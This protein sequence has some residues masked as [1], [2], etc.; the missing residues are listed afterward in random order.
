[1]MAIAT[2]ADLRDYRRY[3]GNIDARKV[4]QTWELGLRHNFFHWPLEFKEVFDPNGAHRGFDVVLGNPPWERIKLQEKEWFANR[5]PAIANAPNAAARHQ[6]IEA[7][8]K[9][10]PT[11]H[12]E[13]LAD[14][15][16][17][18]CG[19]HFVRNSGRYPLCGRGDVNT[20][21][22]FAELARQLINDRGRVGII[23]PTGIA[24]DDTT[25]YFFQSLM[26]N[27]SLVSLYD[28]ENR[29]KLFSA[30]D[31][32]M[33]FCLLTLTGAAQ[34]IEQGAEFIFFAQDV[35]E[36]KDDARRFTLSAAEI[37]LLNPNTRTC[38]IF[39]SKRDAELT[40]AIYQRVPVLIKESEAEENPWGLV[41]RR[42]YDMNKQ[43]VLNKCKKVERNNL[44]LNYIPMMESKLMHQFDSRWA[45][46]S[47]DNLQSISKIN[48]SDSKLEVNP[49][50]EIQ[51]SEVQAQLAGI[52]TRKWLLCWRDI[53]RNTDER[54]I[55]CSILPLSGTDFTIRVGFPL[56]NPLLG[57]V[58]LISSFNSFCVDYIARQMVSGTHLSDYITK[59]LALL[60]ISTFS[61]QCQWSASS[62]NTYFDW[63][64]PRV[65]ELTYTAWDLQPFARDCGY[66]GP[67]FRW[68]EERRFLLR[69]ELDAAYFHLY[70][71]A[72]DDVTY[73]LETF[74]I[75]KRKDEERYGVYR[76]QQ[77][78][79]AI[80]DA[81]AQAITTGVAY[82]TPLD[83]PPADMRVAHGVGVQ[84]RTVDGDRRQPIRVEITEETV[85]S[86]VSV[87]A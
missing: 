53:C 13:F 57:S 27:R 9:E 33:K 6:Q 44:S 37:A 16:A 18:E 50:Y 15:R 25:K 12:A 43:D 21:T 36:L 10:D 59:Q 79:L 67:P 75:I 49:R 62:S 58:A 26:D 32:R 52:W 19:S 3:G 63:L 45:T 87:R 47:D 41:I 66:A 38:P 1:M 35:A 23:V 40:K 17:A 77:V 5:D 30:V 55:I 76:T 48:K 56:A 20:Y 11:L 51:R 39:R 24:T 80:Y 46:Y 68:D 28:F 34:P 78:I 54:T 8:L 81:I 61:E 85:L 60:P 65:L 2:S 69:C 70:G 64:L 7:L 14:K 84:P 82:Q 83:P 42:V 29:K 22:I 74:P 4:G 86:S 73:I 31:S 71:I 72:R